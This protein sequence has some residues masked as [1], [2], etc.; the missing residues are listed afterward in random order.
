[1][2]FMSQG[3]KVFPVSSGPGS[4]G[5]FPGAVPHHTGI[6][7]REPGGTGHVKSVAFGGPRLLVYVEMTWRLPGQNCGCHVARSLEG[8]QERLRGRKQGD[9]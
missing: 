7:Q 1:M 5:T 4:G 6:S 8:R 9:H 2:I 3:E